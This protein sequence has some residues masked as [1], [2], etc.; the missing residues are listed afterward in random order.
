MKQIANIVFYK[1][2]NYGIETTEAC[3]FYTDGTAEVASYEQGID[4]CE[5]LLKNKKIFTKEE[6]EEVLNNDLIYTMTIEDFYDNYGLLQEKSLQSAEFIEEDEEERDDSNYYSYDENG[7]VVDFDYESTE[8]ENNFS[9]KQKNIDEDFDTGDTYGDDSDDYSS[10]SSIYNS[11]N[12][13][14]N[15][16]TGEYNDEINLE[17]A[18]EKKGL[19]ARIK[20]GFKNKINNIMNMKP[21][22]RLRIASL[23]IVTAIALVVTGCGYNLLFKSKTGKMQ[24]SN[25]ETEAMNDTDIDEEMTFYEDNLLYND[26]TSSQ[27][28]EVTK[29]KPQKKAMRKIRNILSKYNGKF[30]NAHVESDKDVKAALTFDEVAALQ[31]AYNDYSSDQVQAI[32]NGTKMSAN[33]MTAD[34]KSATLQLMGAYVIETRENP[35]DMSNLLNNDQE[36]E[37]YK[38]RHEIFMAAKE[39]TGKDKLAKIREF[40]DVC[41]KDFPIS[42]EERTEGIMHT[43]V[44][45]Q[46]ESYKLS[47]VPMIAAAEQMYQNLDPDYTLNDME[48]YFMNDIGLCNYAQQKFEQVEEITSNSLED[49]TNPTY[50]QYRN[51]IIKEMQEKDQYTIDD[52]HRDLSKLNAYQNNVNWHFDL[53]RQSGKTTSTN[54]T[55]STTTETNTWT[56]QT[57]T[58]NEE[59][60]SK[61]KNIPKK[62]KKK[63]DKEIEK[64]NKKVKK[65]AEKEAQKTQQE[66]QEKADEEAV[67]VQ[68]E[69]DQINQETQNDIDA[70]NEQIDKNNSDTDTTNDN[71]I[72]ESDI[73]EGTHFD[74]EHS[75][76]SGDLNDSVED[77]TVDPSGDQTDVELPD[78]NQ[79]GAEFDQKIMEYESY[80]NSYSA[81]EIVDAYVENLANAPESE[82]SLQYIY[83]K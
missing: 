10:D 34:Y 4:A 53:N 58:Y 8:D 72:N 45:K 44:D 13:P 26:Y 62:Y 47:I 61:E 49:T 63:I 71:P 14:S 79:T 55:S 38:S 28:L 9:S 65:E 11:P 67:K 83:T 29:S 82:E 36:K 51:A 37:F 52:E 22:K 35:V 42:I 27:L 40:L 43:N 30:A 70:A 75:N 48:T 57:T 46:I 21:I 33:D 68:Q 1:Y 12:T 50:E 78:P 81:E 23:A 18:K 20:E 24:N 17:E 2:N 41:R 25:I 77:I 59:T 66:M 7:N 19:W 5:E 15:T 32:F 54:S 69:V 73:G 80:N 56:T 74:D 64:E 60:T 16:V 31:I 76:E 6:L 39:S 3:V